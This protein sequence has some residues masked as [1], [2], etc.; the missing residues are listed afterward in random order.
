MN[1]RRRPLSLG[2][3]RLVVIGLN[4]IAEARHALAS[5]ERADAFTGAGTLVEGALADSLVQDVRALAR[6]NR[7]LGDRGD[8]VRAAD[9][10]RYRR[11]P[12]IYVAPALRQEIDQLGERVFAEHYEGRDGLRSVDLALLVRLIG[13]R[14]GHGALLSYLFFAPRVR[15]RTDRTR[16][17]PRATLA[18][19]PH[20]ARRALAIQLH[21]PHQ[22]ADRVSF[23]GDPVQGFL[24]VIGR[25]SPPPE[26]YGRD[27][28]ALNGY[29]RARHI[30]AERASKH[31]TLHGCGCWTG[32]RA[33]PRLPGPTCRP[34]RGV[35][36]HT[37]TAAR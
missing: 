28:R 13:G 14:P 25:V 34:A 18:C 22:L 16:P 19:H 29:V 12:F 35:L 3:D 8:E 6:V 26:R 33:R 17:Q 36:A 37:P 32:L 31:A 4:A 24:Q 20:R 11:I 27:A 23:S 1:L 10:W 5:D 7:M 30:A 21:Q 9:G 15:R 2:V